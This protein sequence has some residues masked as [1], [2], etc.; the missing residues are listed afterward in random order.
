M[1]VKHAATKH[2]QPSTIVVSSRDGRA[3]VALNLSEDALGTIIEALADQRDPFGL[4][5]TRLEQLLSNA[6]RNLQDYE[7]TA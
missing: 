1:S 5:P 2:S 3:R 4:E 6:H 7:R